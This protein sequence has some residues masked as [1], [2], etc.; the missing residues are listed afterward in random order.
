MIRHK[1]VPRIPSSNCLVDID[2]DEDVIKNFQEKTR[3]II[4]DNK[5]KNQYILKFD[6]TPC[7]L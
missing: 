4:A 5:I 6:E 2:I 1:S 3:Q 7:W